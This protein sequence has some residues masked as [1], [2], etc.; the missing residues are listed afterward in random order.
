[1]RALTLAVLTLFAMAQPAAAFCGLYVAKADADLFN[2][3]SKVVY[4]RDGDRSVITMASDY[5][6]EP[7]EFAMVIPTPS[8]LSERQ[9]HVTDAALVDHLDAYTAPRLVE[10]FDEDPC[11]LR[12]KMMRSTA[13]QED[14][15]QQSGEKSLGVTVEASYTIGE[16]DIQI[17]SADQS[18]G[19]AA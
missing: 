15:A 4:M 8:I 17:L 19:L 7:A 6:G 10:Y 9:I 14:G 18:G 12:I 11:Q 16:Y 3:A 2:Q 5:E 1:M 13:V